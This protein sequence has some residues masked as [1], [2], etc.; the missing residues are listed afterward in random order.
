MNFNEAYELSL[1]LMRADIPVALWGNPGVGKSALAAKLAGD[2]NLELIDIRLGQLE[3][4]DL[5]GF[6]E[7]DLVRGTFD[8]LP[9]DKFPLETDPLPSGK[10]GWLILFNRTFM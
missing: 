9:W 4:T 10:E 3:P 6:P 1:T 2:F 7:K 5:N 8:Y